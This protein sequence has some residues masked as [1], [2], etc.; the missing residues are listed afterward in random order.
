MLRQK[1]YLSKVNSI[2]T[3]E[4][5]L[6]KFLIRQRIST[7]AI[8]ALLSGKQTYL[9]GKMSQMIIR[10]SSD[11]SNTSLDDEIDYWE[12]ENKNYYREVAASTDKVD[13]RIVDLYLLRKAGQ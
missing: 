8:L 4:L 5:N 6:K 7:H 12:R 1:K 10:E 3:K 13:K 9:I 11:F 2:L